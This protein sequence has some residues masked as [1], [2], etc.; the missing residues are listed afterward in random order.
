LTVTEITTAN[1]DLGT[2]SATDADAGDTFTYTLEHNSAAYFA[3]DGNTH[4]LAKTVDYETTKYLNITVRVTDANSHTFSKNFTFDIDDIND[5]T[6]SCC[7][8]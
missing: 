1:T 2:H 6:P 5:E 8:Q 7:R 3:I 4:K